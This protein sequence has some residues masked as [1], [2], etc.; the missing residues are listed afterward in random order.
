MR[1]PR[2]LTC[3]DFYCTWNG[4]NYAYGQVSVMHVATATLRADPRYDGYRQAMS[5]IERYIVRHGLTYAKHR[6]IFPAPF[7]RRGIVISVLVVHD[8]AYQ[9]TLPENELPEV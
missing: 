9:R 5:S 2:G 3:H 4:K 1:K 7:G 6:G 8:E